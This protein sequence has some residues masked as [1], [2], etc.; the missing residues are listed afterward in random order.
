MAILAKYYGWTPQEMK[1]MTI[2]EML[3][4]Y[5]EAVDMAKPAEE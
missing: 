2:S 4:Y 3:Q 5:H 1:Q